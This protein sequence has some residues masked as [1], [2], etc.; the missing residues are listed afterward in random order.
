M[1]DGG[2]A[3]MQPNA[4]RAPQASTRLLPAAP[5]AYLVK[6]VCLFY[7]LLCTLMTAQCSL[8]W[9][10]SAFFMYAREHATYAGCSISP[11]GHESNTFLFFCR[12]RVF[13]A[14]QVRAVVFGATLATGRLSTQRCASLVMLGSIPLVL[15]VRRAFLA[16]YN[17]A[18]LM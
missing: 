14:Q 9:T 13:T 7:V 2:L 18:K 8:V 17:L 3:L 10:T 5:L 1:L 12:R 11:F 4:E 16:R 15:E 6:Y